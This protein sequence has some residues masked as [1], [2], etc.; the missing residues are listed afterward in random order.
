MLLAPFS[1]FIGGEIKHQQL[2]GGKQVVRF[3]LAANDRY[4]DAQGNFQERETVWITCQAWNELAARIVDEFTSGT[5]VVLLGRWEQSN[6]VVDGVNKS[7]RF[8]TVEHIGEDLAIPTK[9]GEQQ[10]KQSKPQ[11]QQEQETTQQ[12]SKDEPTS[13]E[14][15]EENPFE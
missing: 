3:R 15:V 6:Y 4:R 8:V 7:T 2:D 13:G 14:I 11:G 12:A 10:E 1:G 5:P 9:R